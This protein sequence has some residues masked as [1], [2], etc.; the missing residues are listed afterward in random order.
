MRGKL[1]QA[2][3]EKDEVCRNFSLSRVCSRPILSHF[4]YNT[5]KHN[6]VL[7]FLHISH[8]QLIQ[9]SRD[10][11]GRIR[12]TSQVTLSIHVLLYAPGFVMD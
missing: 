3:T 7:E 4:H 5:R 1:K 12:A 10:Y 11:V 9:K 2:D 6:F 8:P